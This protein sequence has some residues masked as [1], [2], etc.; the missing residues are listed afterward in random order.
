MSR[1]IDWRSR[2]R[3]ALEKARRV[4]VKVGN[5]VLTTDKGSP[6]CDINNRNSFFIE[7]VSIKRTLN[8]LINKFIEIP[9]S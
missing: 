9:V 2:R 6:F 7:T 5:A 4:V 3:Q 8:H 1:D